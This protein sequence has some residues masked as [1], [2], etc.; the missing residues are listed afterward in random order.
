M[1]AKLILVA[2]ALLLAACGGQGGQGAQPRG[3]STPGGTTEVGPAADC[4]E[5]SD[6]TAV[7]ND[8]EPICV[9]AAAATEVSV[10][11]DGFNPH[12]FTI[13]DT[14]VDER[15]DPGDEVSVAVPD[16]LEPNAE[17]EFVCRIH[18]SM[19]GYLYVT[20]A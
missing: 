13:R 15:L 5:T 20:E 12:T 1:R 8:F 4:I 10:T 3:T 18:P 16:T 6:I 14:E 19:V 2:V 17:T 9:I 7:D 11:N